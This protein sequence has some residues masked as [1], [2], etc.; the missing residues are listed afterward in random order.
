[1]LKD[2]DRSRARRLTRLGVIR[3]GHKESKEKKRRDGSTYTVE[4]PVQ[5]NH[6]IFTDAPDLAEYYGDDCHEMDVILP[7]PD[8][9][10][11]FDAFYQIWAGGTLVCKGDGDCVKYAAPFTV[12][13]KDT[14]GVS[15]YRAKGDTLVSDGVAQV[16][17]SWNGERFEPGEIVT[18]PGAAQG[19]YPH[20]AACKLSGVL[21]IMIA[22]P[23][24]FRFGYYQIATGSG[25]NYDS[26]LGTLELISANGQRP[27]NGFPFK[28]RLVKEATT[29]TENGERKATEK[30]F[31]KLEPDPTLTRKLYQAQA[32]AT[33]GTIA[34]ITAN[35]AGDEAPAQIEAGEYFDESPEIAPPYAEEGG[36]AESPESNEES[37]EGNTSNE[38]VVDAVIHAVI[39]EGL[40]E[41]EWSFHNTIRKSTLDHGTLTPEQA[42]EWFKHY[43]LA[44]DAGRS[45]DEA[46]ERANDLCAAKNYVTPNGARLGDLGADALLSAVEQIDALKNPS[47]KMIA[48][49]KHCL[50][51][52]GQ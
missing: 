24:I 25:R 4:Y 46:A 30:W 31:L 47:A 45:S 26:I 52:L 14:G 38:S 12:K 27:V 19:L 48:A 42:I 21:K 15:V 20:C 49:K 16:A 6:F 23:I 39:G 29:Y 51:L 9:T 41:N 22:D 44:R 8:I 32:Q 40:T 5:D 18:C 3:L 10:R 11:N 43:R 35:D 17:F 2:R 13:E 36:P 34:A 28:L 37:D 1:M 50:V 7:F 33:F